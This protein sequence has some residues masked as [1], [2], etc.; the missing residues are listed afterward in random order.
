M[1]GS[2]DPSLAREM[3][4]QRSDLRHVQLI[5]WARG[6]RGVH[7][8]FRQAVSCSALSVHLKSELANYFAL[9]A[10]SRSGSAN[11]AHVKQAYGEVF[12][13]RVLLEQVIERAVERALGTTLD[14][15]RACLGKGSFFGSSKKQGTSLRMP[16]S[17]CTPTSLCKGACYAH[18]VLDATPLAVVRGALNG[19]VARCYEAGDSHLRTEI[20]VLLRRHSSRAISNA[21]S[22]LVALPADFVRR[23]F[24]RFSHVGEVTKYPRFANA[25]AALIKHESN[26][27]VDCIVYTRHRNA[28]R[29]D[30]DLW[31]INF[32]LDPASLDRKAWAPAHARIVFSAFNGITSNLAEVNFLEHHRHIHMARSSGDGRICPATK[33]ETKM[34]TCDACRCNRC[35]V[36]PVPRQA[37]LTAPIG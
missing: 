8:P 18:D 2:S 29:L 22:E 19:W 34:R 14:R 28:A 6:F 23:P 26:G 31:V 1:R 32:T 12:R 10:L 9:A 30:P 37:P 13:I 17:T 36:Q 3:S 20:M 7:R 25:L 21:R 33:P 27:Q 16:L 5:N 24:I 15:V 11:P 4:N 35:F